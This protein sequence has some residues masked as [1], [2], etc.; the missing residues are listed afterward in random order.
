MAVP[1]HRLAHKRFY[2]RGTQ[3]RIDRIIVSLVVYININGENTMQMY[4]L[5]WTCALGLC[6][7]TAA[8]A[9]D[10]LRVGTS[11]NQMPWGFY[12]QDQKPTGV[13]VALCGALAERLGKTGEFINLD[14]KGL[15][16]ALQASRFDIACAA[17]YITPER[18][19]AILMVP[20]IQ[21]SQTVITHE[22]A[23]IDGLTGLCGH[24][25]SVLQ[26]SGSL[27]VLE[28]ASAEC[29]NDGS[30]AISIQSFDSQPVAMRALE[31]RSVD[32]FIATDSLVSYYMKQRPGLK[33]IAT[34][35]KPTTL[36]I[37]VS[38]NGE[39][40]AGQLR[41]GL[42]AMMADGTYAAILKQW[43]IESAAIESFE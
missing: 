19:D 5:A 20:Y 15:I 24:S 8:V 17:M 6:M 21:A 32:A 14:F 27:K 43:D 38:K 1:D 13:D 18:Q 35:I 7:T 3:K 26:G 25:V 33:K 16:P 34:G 42:E 12:D 28:E 41:E 36:G 9:Q 30:N 10:T 4:R 22:D 2:H 40:L 11:L 23:Q 39:E 37:G 31:N 29:T